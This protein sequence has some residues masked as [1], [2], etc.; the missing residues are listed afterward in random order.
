MRILFALFDAPFE[1]TENFTRNRE[2]KRKMRPFIIG[3]ATRF[4]AILS[5]LVLLGSVYYFLIRPAQIRWGATAEELALPMPE[6]NI[7]PRPVFDATRAITIRATPE[8]IW[9]WLVQM[10]YKRAGFYGYD[11][12][13][14]IGNGSDIRSAT[15]I[16]PAYQH[17]QIGDPIPLSFAATLVFGSINPNSWI[18]WRSR[19]RPTYGVFIWELVPVDNNSTRL[20]SRIR[21]NYAPGS[22]SKVLGLFTEFADHVAVRRILKGVRDRAERRPSPS[23]MLEELEIAGWLVALFEFCLAIGFVA[24][25]RRW[26]I[27]WV[28]ALG[29]GVLL[30]FILYSDVPVWIRAVLPWLYLILIIRFWLNERSSRAQGSVLARQTTVS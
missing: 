11:L 13:E 18:V 23:L 12:I 9:P 3:I 21:W 15:T 2:W 17:P 4:A 7:V 25:W 6:D 20:I 1:T 16:L 14:S 30:Q 22:W 27:A 28:L 5:L 10:G 19:D 8:T 29:A 26:Q 24:T